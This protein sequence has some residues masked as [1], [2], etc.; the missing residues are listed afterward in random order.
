MAGFN[1]PEGY[2]LGRDSEGNVILVPSTTKASKGPSF[3][4]DVVSKAREYTMPRA[5]DFT[6][7]TSDV[8]GAGKDL[9]Q[10]GYE[11]FKSNPLYGA[12]QVAAGSALSALSPVAGAIQAGI[13]N[14]AERTFGPAVGHAAEVGTT[15]IPGPGEASSAARMYAADLLKAARESSIPHAGISPGELAVIQAKHPGRM[16]NPE[17]G[18]PMSFAGK[19]AMTTGPTDPYLGIVDKAQE[20]AGSARDR[21]AS[22]LQPQI[23][24]NPETGAKIPVRDPVT[25]RMVAAEPEFSTAQKAGYST[26]VGAPLVAAGYLGHQDEASPASAIS[27]ADLFDMRNAEVA[28]YPSAEDRAAYSQQQQI[29][30]SRRFPSAPP[31]ERHVAP[32]PATV[33]AAP[34][35][36]Q[37]A[38]A[39]E[40]SAPA[41]E[42]VAQVQQ[43][44]AKPEEMTL[45]QLWDAAN[46]SGEARDFFRADQAMQAMKNAQGDSS[47]EGKKAG[48]SVNGKDAAIHKA[49]EIIHHMITNR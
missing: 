36:K 49:L 41:P 26:A 32:A 24:R 21:L 27:P 12:G 45:R 35:P 8:Y 31:V 39:P 40:Q 44:A 6:D 11:T 18:T 37:S 19:P 22:A 46:A 4:D 38:P 15:F 16:I 30:A 9:S 14:P 29:N 23:P 1:I 34:V 17:N 33:R 47:P 13:I 48:G 28:R 3:W 42:Q 25:G 2:E 7:T 20:V 5:S 43:A 10:R